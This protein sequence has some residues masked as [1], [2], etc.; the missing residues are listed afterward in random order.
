MRD[1]TIVL[2]PNRKWDHWYSNVICKV[3]TWVTR[4]RF[5]HVKVYLN[6]YWYESEY[7]EGAQENLGP[8]NPTDH[9]L[10]Q[11][12]RE[13]TAGERAAMLGHVERAIEDGQRYNTPKLFFLLVGVPLRKLFSRLGWMPF[14]DDGRYGTV[15]FNFVDGAFKAAGIDLFPDLFEEATT[16]RDF[17]RCAFFE[18]VEP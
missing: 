17:E 2:I 7:P 5:I 3:I 6:G 14:Q 9:T 4:S 12:I 11:P 18:D 8:F 10:R 16:G 15:C 1:G 13:L